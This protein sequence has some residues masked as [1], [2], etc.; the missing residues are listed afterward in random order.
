[1]MC[2]LS[3]PH[4]L[5]EIMFRR[6]FVQWQTSLGRVTLNYEVLF[7][8]MSHLWAPLVLNSIRNVLLNNVQFV[9]RMNGGVKMA[10]CTL[11][12]LLCDF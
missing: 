1:M 8:E 6:Q 4:I 7:L 2:V 3:S 10:A 9:I 11:H 12:H 5:T